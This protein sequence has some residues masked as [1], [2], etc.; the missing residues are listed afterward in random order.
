MPETGFNVAKIRLLAFLCLLLILLFANNVYAEGAS[1]GE[2]KGI[3]PVSS[4]HSGSSSFFR[5]VEG[6]QPLF[7]SRKL[8]TDVQFMDRRQFY[9]THKTVVG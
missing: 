5:Q 1:V 8:S 3:M 2:Q 9:S 4:Y 6:I 7:E